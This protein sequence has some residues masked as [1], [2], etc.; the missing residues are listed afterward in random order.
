MIPSTTSS[1]ACTAPPA[2][3]DADADVGPDADVRPDGDE[4]ADADGDDADEAE[5]DV[6]PAVL[7]GPTRLADGA[8]DPVL[9]D[10][11]TCILADYLAVNEGTADAVVVQRLDFDGVVVGSSQRYA[12]PSVAELRAA[13][14]WA[15]CGTTAALLA[16]WYRPDTGSWRPLLLW[17]AWDG[18]DLVV[19]DVTASVFGADT[20]A[21]RGF[22]VAGRAG[23]EDCWVAWIHDPDELPSGGMTEIRTRRIRGLEAGDVSAVV[24]AFNAGD[25]WGWTLEAAGWFPTDPHPMPRLAT[26]VDGTG[27]LLVAVAA[28]DNA[29][30]DL[31]DVLLLGQQ[32]RPDGSVGFEGDAV[33]WARFGSPCSTPCEGIESFEAPMLAAAGSYAALAYVLVNQ[34]GGDP[35]RRRLMTQTIQLTSHVPG[36][37]R[38]ETWAGPP[39]RITNL[40]A[41][42]G[43]FFG[44][45]SQWSGDISDRSSRLHFFEAAVGVGATSLWSSPGMYTRLRPGRDDAVIASWY[46]QEEAVPGTPTSAELVVRMQKFV[47]GA[48]APDWPDDGFRL[49]D[50]AA[51]DLDGDVGCLPQGVATPGGGA[52][53]AFTSRGEPSGHQIQVVRVVPGAP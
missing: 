51:Y 50:P 46:A 11:D 16:H 10:F 31:G 26:A 20:T 39:V 3:A 42:G 43:Q 18:S 5:A 45:V 40:V 9:L 44:A 30:A 36:M 4:G 28:R 47:G 38:E 29:G 23:D 21:L 12:P 32:V 13:H 24:H 17:V 37:P 6:A 34:E 22:G 49:F 53:T 41:A 19:H 48:R 1:A 2:D 27:N 33:V 7:V 25:T 52:L 14:D 15:R 8:T 35:G